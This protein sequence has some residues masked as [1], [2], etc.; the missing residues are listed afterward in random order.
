M[1]NRLASL[2]MST[3][4]LEALPGKLDSSDTRLGKSRVAIIYFGILVRTLIEKQF[5]PLCQIGSGKRLIRPS[6]K[7]CDDKEKRCHD[8]PPLTLIEFL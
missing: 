3:S 4:I 6:V 1:L 7:Y 8:P 5:D 2:A